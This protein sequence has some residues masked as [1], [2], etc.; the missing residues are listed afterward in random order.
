MKEREIE[1]EIQKNRGRDREKKEPE[2]R[3]GRKRDR[4]KQTKKL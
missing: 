4:N 1:E 3:E 2:W